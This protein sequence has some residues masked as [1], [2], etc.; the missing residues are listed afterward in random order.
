ME[1]LTSIGQL[2]ALQCVEEVDVIQNSS[3]EEGFELE[4]S[5]ISINK[6]NAFGQ[7]LILGE[8]PQSLKSNF[9]NDT[10]RRFEVPKKFI[11]SIPQPLNVQ[12]GR[13]AFKIVAST[14]NNDGDTFDFFFP[15][16]KCM[17]KVVKV[18]LEW[19]KVVVC[20]KSFD[21]KVISI[22]ENAWRN[23]WEQVEQTK[24]SKDFVLSNCNLANM[25]KNKFNI[26]KLTVKNHQRNLALVYMCKVFFNMVKSIHMLKI[27]ENMLHSTP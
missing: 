24:C 16:A 12:N 20:M 14:E 3:L 7:Q 13:N 21:V 8:T 23:P 9:A 25:N 26:S 5:P 6:S 1:L 15:S 18:G 4:E 19:A 2:N 22:G 27:K 17:T 10:M 11:S